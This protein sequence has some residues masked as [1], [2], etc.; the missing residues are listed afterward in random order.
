MQTRKDDNAFPIFD[1]EGFSLS[2][3][4]TKREYFAAA[5][6]QGLLATSVPLGGKTVAQLAVEAADSLIFELNKQPGRQ[7]YEK[8]NSEK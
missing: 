8:P 6:L 5:A 1:R 2:E 3:G 7:P 4:I